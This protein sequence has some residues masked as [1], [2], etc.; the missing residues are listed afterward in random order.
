MNQVRGVVLCL[1]Y[2]I[3]LMVGQIN[4]GG[5]VL[6]GLG[7]FASI[8]FPILIRKTPKPRRQRT[9]D[10]N[11]PLPPSPFLFLPYSFF[12]KWLWIS[13]GIIGFLASIYFQYRI[14]VPDD[15]DI[16]K[17]LDQQNYQNT[18]ITVYG[19]IES[20]PRLT[21]AGKI[22]FIL[23]AKHVNEING[24]NGP[25]NVN[26]PVTGKIYV[27]APLLQG[28][29][30]YPGATVGITGKLY[31]P[32]KRKNPGG[33]D[34][35]EFL[36]NEGIFAG[37]SARKIEGNETGESPPLSFFS[38]RRR[39]VK[40]MIE[41]LGIPEGAL[42]SA[43]ALGKQAI[44]LPYHI[45]DTFVLAGLAHAIAASGTQ[46][47]LILGVV[48]AL[49]KGFSKTIKFTLGI[50][51]LIILLGLTGLEPSIVRAAFMGVLT[52]IAIVLERQIKPLGALL[53][54]ATVLLLINPLWIEDLGFQ[55][56]FL[57]TLGLVVTAP[58]LM[59][60]LDF[61]PI[62]IASLIAIPI[63]AS[64]WTLP[65]LAA[66]FSCV[67]P[68]CIITNILASV[69]ITIISI[70]GFITA[71]ASFLVPSLGKAISSLLYYP[72]YGLIEL[73]DYFANLP[74]NRVNVGNV[75][76]IQEIALYSLFIGVWG[77]GTFREK[78]REAAKTQKQ[79]IQPQKS[80]PL[81]PFAL[82][83]AIGI[84]VL[85]A[86]KYQ[87]STFKVTILANTKEPV[88]VSNKRGEITLINSGI[89]NDVT[90]T[91]FPFL[92]QEGVNQIKYAIATHTRLGLSA[93]WSNLIGQLPIQNFY[94]IP[95][96]QQ[97][98]YNSN[99]T[100]LKTL[101]VR[102]G[103]YTPLQES[104]T[105]A[106]DSLQVNVINSDAPVVQFQIDNK[107]WLLVGDLPI[108]AQNTLALN[109]N[110]KDIKVILWSGIPLSQEF[111]SVIQP[112]IAIV[113]GNAIDPETE[114]RLRVA[115]TLIYLTSQDGAIEWTPEDGFLP[116]LESDENLISW[117]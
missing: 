97:A 61:L 18:L 60:I 36:E 70:G 69:L 96:S 28:T 10:H 11:N 22:Q 4:W 72:T 27:T 14:P 107:K 110:I 15:N 32:Q 3:G 25:A 56:S 86:W 58:P 59:K 24:I 116:T 63:A 68:Y 90:Y 100:F 64:I 88:L 8:I 112:E 67:L 26:K 21:R 7:V 87:I 5:Y 49:T 1:A 20:T 52:L 73:A 77:I 91:V 34:F 101:K 117:P 57:A 29:G 81:V 42:V 54:A 51:S 53:L 78:Q 115:K 19:E 74:G 98:Y 46:V 109:G 50:T 13:A 41:G 38:I 102:Q 45:K 104:Q 65:R 55:L 44:D 82:I 114:R 113:S 62:P 16:S 76:I 33:F 23:D 80:L 48:L 31:A 37:F 95:S 83:I 103:I 47:S 17:L 85:P 84:I 75:S 39:I 71:I 30:L 35:K 2:I 79:K 92:A 89:E 43:I 99:Q 93:G 6:L 40:P 105:I 111:I 108:N 9:E 106:L 66:V 12:N 94:D